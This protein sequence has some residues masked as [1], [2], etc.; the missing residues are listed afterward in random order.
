MNKLWRQKRVKDRA[1]RRAKGDSLLYGRRL[2]STWSTTVYH[3]QKTNSVDPSPIAQLAD[4]MCGYMKDHMFVGEM[5]SVDGNVARISAAVALD[6]AVNNG[7]DIRL[8]LTM[9]DFDDVMQDGTLNGAS[10]MDALAIFASAAKVDGSPARELMDET[11]AASRVI[12][13]LNID[14]METNTPV[15]PRVSTLPVGAVSTPGNVEA[16]T[17]ETTYWGRDGEAFKATDYKFK[18]DFIA[19]N[20]AVFTSKILSAH[21]FKRNKSFSKQNFRVCLV[22]F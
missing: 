21:E 12:K 11:S 9:S 17:K 22:L 3:I 19:M 14:D 2:L 4:F 15:A 5:V 16:E 8:T 10:S 13:S 6:S 18:L 1:W 7:S 20:G